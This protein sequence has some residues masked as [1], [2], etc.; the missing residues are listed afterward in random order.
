MDALKA[1]T[2]SSS[3]PPRFTHDCSV[4]SGG[5]LQP[6]SPHARRMGLRACFCSHVCCLFGRR[7][8][9]SRCIEWMVAFERSR[10]HVTC[11][12]AASPGAAGS[13]HVVLDV[14][15]EQR[16]IDSG[17]ASVDDLMSH[18]TG[19]R[20]KM[21]DLGSDLDFA[22]K[23]ICTD[24][25]C[26][27]PHITLPHRTASPLNIRRL[28]PMYNNP[29]QP[30]PPPTLPIYTHWLSGCTASNSKSFQPNI[31]DNEHGRTTEFVFISFLRKQHFMIMIVPGLRSPREMCYVWQTQ[32]TSTQANKCATLQP[33]LTRTGP[34]PNLQKKTGPQQR[35]AA[36][37]LR[38][39][40]AVA[41]RD[42]CCGNGAM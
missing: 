12:P 22:P 28:K 36:R 37:G 1:S 14:S 23:R 35:A 42:I 25:A 38:D 29:R 18:Q 20:T 34:N 26:T 17:G 24:L 6:S 30:A 31:Q 27:P 9:G 11:S 40:G 32:P 19:I 16:S 41:D 33:K 8:A 3:P 2:W 7:A 21:G 15:E 39:S 13:E 10:L 4:W 5:A